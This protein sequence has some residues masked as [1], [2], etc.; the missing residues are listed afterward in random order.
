MWNVKSGS[1]VRKLDI[2]SVENGIYFTKITSAEGT[3]VFKM[4]KE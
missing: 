2:T 1:N 3:S 4:I